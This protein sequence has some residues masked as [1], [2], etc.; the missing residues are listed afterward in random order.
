MFVQSQRKARGGMRSKRCPRCGEVK[1]LA[2]F[3]LSP[4]RPDGRSAHCGHCYNITKSRRRRTPEARQKARMWHVARRDNGYFRDRQPK[5]NAYIREV[6]RKHPEQHAARVALRDAVRRGIVLKSS[7][8][9]KCG[10]GGLLHGHHHKGYD[11][12]LEVIWL[13]VVCHARLHGEARIPG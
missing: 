9:S 10:S 12:P 6:K 2:E 4:T 5:R 1:S 3:H 13:C 8:C 7:T 11:Y